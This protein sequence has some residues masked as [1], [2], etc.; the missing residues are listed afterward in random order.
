[1]MH[2]AV[3]HAFGEPPRCTRFPPPT[4]EPGEALV[5]VRAAA[6]TPLAKWVTT[7]RDYA[8]ARRTPFVCGTEG[9]GVLQDGSRVAFGVLRAPYG[10]MAEYAVAPREFC[11]PVPDGLGDTAAAGL[12]HPALSAWIAITRG[13]RL[14]AGE[15]VLVL[16][17]TGVTGT[18]AVRIAKTLGAGRVV[19]A[20]RDPVA[21]T[22]LREAGADSTVQLDRPEAELAAAFAREAGDTGYD[23]VLDYLWGRPAQILLDAL[24]RSFIARSGIRYLQLGSSAGAGITLRAGALRRTGLS[25]SPA[26]VPPADDMR[27]LYATVM[28]HAAR[29]HI[30][31][32]HETVP[33][34]DIEA[35]W[36]RQVRGRRLV[37][38]P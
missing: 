11:F 3:L 23:V 30:S 6:L 17:A 18:C 13:A 14:A 12:V 7:D 25:I 10:S 19:A 20:G 34:R 24:P 8:G 28:A 2:A 4:P 37:V 15:T 36:T 5:R 9:I 32:D 16:G 31:V 29:G 21:L 1:M 22:A 27:E 38:L 33:L 26:P 35:A